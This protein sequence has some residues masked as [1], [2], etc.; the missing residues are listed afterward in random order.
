[1]K[2]KSSMKSY[3]QVVGVVGFLTPFILG[4]C[5]SGTG[6]GTSTG[7]S[8]ANGTVGAAV[9]SIFA[10]EG[11][12][13]SLQ[14]RRSLPLRLV[15][16]LVEEAHADGEGPTSACD[17][18]SSSEGP[19]DV[20]TSATVTAGSYGVTGDE[21][22]VTAADGC[23]QGGDYAS[24]TVA[25]HTMDCTNDGEEMTMT[26]TDSTGVFREDT[27][28]NATKIYG[29]FNVAV[30]DGDAESV[31]CS[32][33]ILHGSGGA[34]SFTGSCEDSEGEPIEQSDDASCSDQ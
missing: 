16:L 2:T 33:T 20:S 18:A 14:S 34:G 32:F 19:D 24:F 5:S 17:I 28:E 7:S 4:A 9:G 11:D 23:D 25:S 31:E 13:A 10:S 12:N 29:S 22:T 3:L 21:V 30:G 27:D 26:M 1:M 6:G 15:A 8:S